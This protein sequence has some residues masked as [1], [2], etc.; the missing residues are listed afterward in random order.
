M[1]KKIH[2]SHLNLNSRIND[3]NEKWRGP[4]V[5]ATLLLSIQY[6]IEFCILRSI[7]IHN[8]MKPDTSCEWIVNNTHIAHA[9]AYLWAL[10]MLLR[11]LCHIIVYSP[12][13]WTVNTA[14]D[15]IFVGKLWNVIAETGACTFKPNSQVIRSSRVCARMYRRNNN[16]QRDVLLVCNKHTLES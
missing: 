5:D 3:A 4:I 6:T 11:V 1:R 15:S 7:C 14:P 12:L 13:T 10:D 9:F 8:S 2:K 16:N